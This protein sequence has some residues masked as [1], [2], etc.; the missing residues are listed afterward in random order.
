MATINFLENAKF[1]DKFIDSEGKTYIYH[2]KEKHKS[3][4]GKLWDYHWLIREPAYYNSVVNDVEFCYHPYQSF[5]FIDGYGVQTNL[6]YYSIKSLL[7]GPNKRELIVRK[8]DD[9]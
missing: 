7:E 9:T 6:K 8:C 2:Y 4:D 3:S 5:V 1:G